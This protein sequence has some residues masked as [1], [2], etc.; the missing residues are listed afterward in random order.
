M[1]EIYSREI[2]EVIIKSPTLREVVVIGVPDEYWGEVVKTVVAHKLG[3]KVTES[4]LIKFCKNRV[5]LAN[6]K[7]RQ[8]GISC[9][10]PQTCAGA[11]GTNQDRVV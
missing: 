8:V 7:L 11:L 4:E 1:K 10:G 6:G 3:Q 9:C 5:A 2:E